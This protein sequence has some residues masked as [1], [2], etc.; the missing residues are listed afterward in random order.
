MAGGLQGLVNALAMGELRQAIGGIGIHPYRTL[1]MPNLLKLKIL[2]V[3]GL[4]KRPKLK[5]RVKVTLRQLSISTVEGT[6][7]GEPEADGVCTSFD[8]NTELLLPLGS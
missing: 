3:R 6:P 4:R 7:S 5:P 2:S 8:F 1:K